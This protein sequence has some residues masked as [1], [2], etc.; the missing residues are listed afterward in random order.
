MI[1]GSLALKFQLESK[2]KQVTGGG[3]DARFTPP[4]ARLRRCHS[5]SKSSSWTVGPTGVPSFRAGFQAP[6][7]GPAPPSPGRA[8]SSPGRRRGPRFPE[9][10]RAPR[11]PAALGRPPAPGTPKGCPRPG[12]QAGGSNRMTEMT[13][14]LTPRRPP[15]PPPE[16]AHAAPPGRS[17]ARSR[18]RRSRGAPPPPPPRPARD[19]PAPAR[20]RRRPPRR[21]GRWR[22][23]RL[24]PARCCGCASCCLLLYPVQLQGHPMP[25]HQTY[26]GS[27]KFLTFIDL[28]RPPPPPPSSHPEPACVCGCVGVYACRRHLAVSSLLPQWLRLKAPL[29]PQ[30]YL[31]KHPALPGSWGYKCRWSTWQGGGLFGEGNTP[32]SK[33]CL[34]KILLLANGSDWPWSGAAWDPFDPQDAFPSTHRGINLQQLEDTGY[35][36]NDF[37]FLW[38]D[39]KSSSQRKLLRKRE[40]A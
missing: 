7:P 13:K 26:R 6:V 1:N 34:G 8:P 19:S 37:S 14:E 25:S 15:G 32:A 12:L 20:A 21:P 22:T 28:V 24:S 30:Q 11:A 4:R 3:W 29:P 39:Q 2:R 5:A 35:L 36:Q 27:W 33:R 40:I 38:K 23:W 9:P 31:R 17:P 16:P 18:S 10:M